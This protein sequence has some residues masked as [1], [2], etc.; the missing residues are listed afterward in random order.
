[1][2]NEI[3]IVARKKFALAENRTWASRVAGENSTT[4]CTSDHAY[5]LQ[6][7][8]WFA[9]WRA[10]PFRHLQC[11]CRVGQTVQEPTDHRKLPFQ[12]DHRGVCHPVN[13]A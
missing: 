11:F 6:E 13:S 4:A 12:L 8:S 9:F 7:D 5:Q 10:S 3:K 2:G 1:M